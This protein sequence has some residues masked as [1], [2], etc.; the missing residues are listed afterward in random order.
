MRKCMH[1]KTLPFHATETIAIV[2]SLINFMLIQH[3]PGVYQMSHVFVIRIAVFS[4]YFIS[5]SGSCPRH[6]FL[7]TIY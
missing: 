4:P 2:P 6:L 3:L 1:K 7:A 5:S